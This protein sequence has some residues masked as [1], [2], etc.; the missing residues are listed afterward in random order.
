M[1]DEMITGRGMTDGMIVGK[2][3]I[4]IGIEIQIIAKEGREVMTNI[5]GSSRSEFIN[6]NQV[7]NRAGWLIVS[8]DNQEMT[9]SSCHCNLQ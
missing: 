9:A 6:L 8:S 4:G 3:M 7:S 1:I 2:G 5:E